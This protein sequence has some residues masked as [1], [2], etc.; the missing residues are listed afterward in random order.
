MQV[1][2]KKK[3]IAHLFF[4]EQLPQSFATFGV[5]L[6]KT[7]RDSLGKRSFKW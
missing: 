7:P 3:A 2:V 5:G 4:A 6:N 1:S